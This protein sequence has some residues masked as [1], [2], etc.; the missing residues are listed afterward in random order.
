LV[1]TLNCLFCLRFSPRKPGTDSNAPSAPRQFHNSG[2]GA[3]DELD[4]TRPVERA[5]EARSADDVAGSIVRTLY[6]AETFL[7]N[8]EEMYCCLH[9][10]LHVI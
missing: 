6:F 1:L 9:L 7:T 5:V 3:S 8:S 10:S 2:G 4:L